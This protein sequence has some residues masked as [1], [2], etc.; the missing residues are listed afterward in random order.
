MSRSQCPVVEKP[1]RVDLLRSR[2]VNGCL[3][4]SEA[5]VHVLRVFG[6]DARHVAVDRS[7]GLLRR[8]LESPSEEWRRSVGDASKSMHREDTERIRRETGEPGRLRVEYW[9]S[10]VD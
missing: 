3:L 5:V 9:H 2:L 10:S 1:W 8:C 4:Q 6:L 7:A